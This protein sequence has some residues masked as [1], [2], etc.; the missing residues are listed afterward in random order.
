MRVPSF[1]SDGYERMGVCMCVHAKLF[2]KKKDDE[3]SL[4]FWIFLFGFFLQAQVTSSQIAL[5]A[6]H[7]FV[8]L[9]KH[10]YEK[11][12]ALFSSRS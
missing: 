7:E 11:S 8:I 3:E 12:V 2:T 10:K 5:P 1:Q 4:I 6:I 9:M